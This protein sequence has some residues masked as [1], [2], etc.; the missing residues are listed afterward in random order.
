MIVFDGAASQIEAD[1][2]RFNLSSFLP[3]NRLRS[4]R[5]QE[6]VL[7]QASR[8]RNATFMGSHL[9]SLTRRGPVAV[10]RRTA[11]VTVAAPEPERLTHSERARMYRSGWF[12]LTCFLV[13]LTL[14][15]FALFV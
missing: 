1:A 4:Q 8:T 7:I 11:E 15:C 12:D 14:L 6:A 2:V 9:G 10:P 3:I 13:L 5:T